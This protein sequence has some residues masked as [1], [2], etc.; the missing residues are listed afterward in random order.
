M[1]GSAHAALAEVYVGSWKR[2][3]GC[4]LPP[5]PPPLPPP[6]R[7]DNP[8]VKGDML[9]GSG[10]AQVST[11]ATSG[12]A[13]GPIHGRSM[14]DGRTP[15]ARDWERDRETLL[16]ALGGEWGSG[17]WRRA[18]GEV[19]GVEVGENVGK[20]EVDWGR[21]GTSS[22]VCAESVLPGAMFCGVSRV[23]RV[24]DSPWAHG[25]RRRR[26]CSPAS[27]SPPRRRQRARFQS[28]PR[29]SSR[30]SRRSRARLQPRSWSRSHPR[31]RPAC[32]APSWAWSR[33]RSARPPAAT[34]RGSCT[35]R[36]CRRA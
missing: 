14:A 13:R 31:S 15:V 27:L 32:P 34:Q 12:L 25:V 1:W 17:C 33:S 22:S 28:V 3:S 4:V 18:A 30:Q 26:S 16:A 8:R 35:G 5:P 9:D 7:A 24:R 6:A 29:P 21:E 20:G 19:E 2:A 11:V 36:A 10:D 23:L